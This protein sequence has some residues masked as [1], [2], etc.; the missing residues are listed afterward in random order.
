MAGFS[1][2]LMFGFR[3]IIVLPSIRWFALLI[4][5]FSVVFYLL[6]FSVLT[7]KNKQTPCSE[8]ASEL[9]RPSDRR[10]SAKLVLTFTDRKVSRRQR[11]LSLAVVISVLYTGAATF[12]FK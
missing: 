4:N 1:A 8:S 5:L 10:L 11:G 6:C 2:Y 3:K 12:Y 9:Y 7:H